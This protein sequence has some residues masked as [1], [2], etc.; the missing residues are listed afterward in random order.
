MQ[1]RKAALAV[2]AGL[3]VLA[4][5][6]FL[7]LRGGSSSGPVTKGVTVITL[8]HGMPVGGVHDVTVDVGD[9]VRVKVHSDINANIDVH[10]YD[11]TKPVKPGG[12]VSYDFP[13]KLDGEFEM[14]AHPIVNGEE[15]ED[16][17]QIVELRV[18]P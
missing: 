8:R 4:V 6:L 2:G 11:F 10:G 17:N 7:V 16:G 15:Q 14:E 1:S 18:N 13:A 9:P 5:V 12:T 3:I